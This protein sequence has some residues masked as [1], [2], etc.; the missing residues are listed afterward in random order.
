MPATFELKEL[1]LPGLET[2]FSLKLKRGEL[3]AIRTLTEQATAQMLQIL[4]GETVQISG[5]VLLEDISLNSL[6]FTSLLDVRKSIATVSSQSVLISNLKVWENIILPNLY[7]NSPLS[8]SDE[9]RIIQ[10][11]EASGYHG[12]IWALPGHLAP[13][14]RLITVF[15]RAVV[16]SP[17]LFIFT[18]CLEMLPQHQKKLLTKQLNVLKEGSDAP[19]MIS[20]SST[21]DLVLG[22]K[23]DISCNLCGT[24][25]QIMR[26][27]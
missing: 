6:E 2:G 24:I 13:F 11:L 5:E 10:L 25:P 17:K 19:V 20:V 12:N 9:N 22:L 27:I 23:P 7:H 3:L 14:E 18:D 1:L 4:L 16:S 21:S 15:V 8:R 26:H